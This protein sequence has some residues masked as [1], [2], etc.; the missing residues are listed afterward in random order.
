MENLSEKILFSFGKHCFAGR[1]APFCGGEKH[2]FAGEEAPPLF[3]QTFF[4]P[5]N[6]ESTKRYKVFNIQ[7]STVNSSTVSQNELRLEKKKVL[8]ILILYIIYNIYYI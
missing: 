3:Q 4:C 8:N 1:K 2:H 5:K 6:S 7:Q